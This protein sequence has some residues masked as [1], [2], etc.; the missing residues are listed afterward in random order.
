ME[1]KVIKAKSIEEMSELL[2]DIDTI[3]NIHW[4]TNIIQEGKYLK[5]IALVSARLVENGVLAV[6]EPENAPK[7]TEL[8]I[9]ST[10]NKKTKETKKAKGVKHGRK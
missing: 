4:L 9:L 3:Y 5:V 8:N 2:K 6:L 1:S 10:E 7:E